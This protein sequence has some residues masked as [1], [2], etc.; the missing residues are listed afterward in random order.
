M[1]RGY[2]WQD[3]VYGGH[4]ELDTTEQLTHTQ[5]MCRWQGGNHL[6]HGETEMSW[7][8]KVSQFKTSPFFG[9]NDQ[10]I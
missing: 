3:I 5:T 7:H 10:V 9:E 1:D 2:I 6:K 4:K 8:K